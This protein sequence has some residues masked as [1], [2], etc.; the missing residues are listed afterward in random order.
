MKKYMKPQLVALS[1]VGNDALCAT[2]CGIDAEGTNMDPTL[3]LALQLAGLLLGND[4]D[5][6]YIPKTAFGTGEACDQD[7]IIDGYCKFGP[8]GQLVFVS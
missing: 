1:L 2:S 8:S 3:K 4:K 7:K 6:F 5:G